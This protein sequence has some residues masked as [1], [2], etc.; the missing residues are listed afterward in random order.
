MKLFNCDGYWQ[1]CKQ[2]FKN[3]IVCDGEWDGIENATD[4]KIFFYT[5][6]LPVVGDHGEFVVLTAEEM[7]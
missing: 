1:D 6:G 3:M 4:E 2:Q 7:A 5:D